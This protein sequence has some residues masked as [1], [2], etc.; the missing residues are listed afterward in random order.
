MGIPVANS[1]SV[2]RVDVKRDP[3]IMTGI[4]AVRST[5]DRRH[6]KGVTPLGKVTHRAKHP[7]IQPHIPTRRGPVGTPLGRISG[8]RLMDII[9][10]RGAIIPPAHLTGQPADPATPLQPASCIGGVFSNGRI[11]GS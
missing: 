4:T 1:L 10:C 8:C 11:A 2:D 9:E 6:P 3:H 5:G 7:G